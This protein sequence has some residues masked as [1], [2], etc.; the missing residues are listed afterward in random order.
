MDTPSRSVCAVVVPCL[1]M[2]AAH[3][4][5]LCLQACSTP[6]VVIPVLGLGGGTARMMRGWSSLGRAHATRVGWVRGLKPRVM[7]Q[8]VR[9]VRTC[10]KALEFLP[11]PGTVAA[12]AKVWG[13]ECQRWPWDLAP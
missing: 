8:D 3:I 11:C 5:R 6:G 7:A 1:P 10:M 13:L 12:G 2:A 9:V 4:T